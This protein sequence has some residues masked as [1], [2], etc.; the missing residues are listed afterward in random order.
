MIGSVWG[1]ICALSVGLC[2]PGSLEF[3]DPTAHLDPAFPPV[4]QTLS[5]SVLLGF[6]AVVM[7]TMTKSNLGMDERV[8][9]ADKP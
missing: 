8:Y 5:I 2:S 9:L 1:D 6:S 4:D 7:N 3:Q